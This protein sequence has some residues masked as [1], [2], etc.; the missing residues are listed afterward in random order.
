MAR[1]RRNPQFLYPLG[2]NVDH[3]VD[4]L[5][6]ALDQQPA[7]VDDRSRFASKIKPQPVAQFEFVEWTA[8]HHL[9]RSKFISLCDDKKAKYLRRE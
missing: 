8:V 4:V 6:G 2:S 9:R 1:K 7:L 5:N 3:A